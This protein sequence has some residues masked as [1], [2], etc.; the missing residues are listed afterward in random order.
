MIRVLH[1]I[2][3]A[4][5]GGISTMLLNYY[6]NINR[7]EIHFDFIYS[8]D[9]P[10]GYNG[11]KLKKLGAEFYYVPRK[12]LD[13]KSHVKGI[14]DVVNNGN[15]DAIHVHSNHTSYVAL[16]VAKKCGI[17]IRVAH[18]HNAVKGWLG[19]KES[20]SRLVGI[21]LINYYSTKCL[22][23]SEDAATYTFGSKSLKRNKTM[24]IHNAID[25]K[26]FG[27]SETNRSAIRM[28][29]GIG[30][31]I[32]VFGTVARMSYEKNIIYLLEVLKEIQKRTRALLFLIG[33][34]DERSKIEAKA[35]ELN[36]SQSV[37]FAGK[38]SDVYRY[39]SAFDVFVIPSLNE[40]FSIAGLEAGANGLPIVMS[41]AVPLELS[42]L[43]NTTYLPLEGEEKKWADTI[44][45]CKRLR[46][47][48]SVLEVEQNGYDIRKTVKILEKVYIGEI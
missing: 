26:A 8:V 33:D 39:L 42:F 36:I 35:Y 44:I 10:L 43:P 6:K 21:L 22:A 48:K 11:N 4:D 19:I 18:A 23:C 16:A 31:E 5:L 12:S 15:Y 46:M 2:N 45:A 40:G 13:L 3:N 27:F 28:E 41:E 32:L 20:V 38:H 37:I 29:Y 14:R 9:E 30:N 25:C 17:K 47:K 24:I 7:D 1:V 34:G